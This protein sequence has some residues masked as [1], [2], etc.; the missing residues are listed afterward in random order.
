METYTWTLV[1]QSF[2]YCNT[3]KEMD[4]PDIQEVIRQYGDAT[5]RC[6]AVVLCDVA[7]HRRINSAIEIGRISVGRE[8][9]WGAP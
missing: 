8:I 9:M 3:P 4:Q 1:R 6:A 7:S 2:L 5:V